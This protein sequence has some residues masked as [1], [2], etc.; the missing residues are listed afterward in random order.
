MQTID[1]EVL[2]EATAQGIV[3]AD[4][5]ERLWTFASSRGGPPSGNR[6]AAE[7]V[8]RFTFTNALYYLGGAL[9]VGAM[10]FFL[11]LGWQRFAGWGVIGISTAY[12]LVAVLLAARLEARGLELPMSL[13]AT[14]AVVLVPV[15]VWGFEKVLGIP[16]GERPIVLEVAA[17]L[18]AIAALAR[19]RSPI[20]VLPVAA[21]LWLASMDI[22]VELFRPDMDSASPA[23]QL[24]RQR[25][26]AVE[27]LLLLAAAFGVDL[28]LRPRRDFAFWIYLAGLAAAWGGITL[29]DAKSLPGT[30]VYLT[31]N[32]LL[33]VLGAVLVRRAFTVFGAVGVAIGLAS[34]GDRY[35]RNSWLFPLA[36]TLI[37]LGVVGFGL[38]WSRNEARLSARLQPLLP[39]SLREAIARR[40]TVR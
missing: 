8:A 30:L 19:F 16:V 1:R 10:G 13:L 5:A 2:A 38:W 11:E 29:M 31:G 28:R 26:S 33:V 22:T 9:A 32:A 36:L 21:A 40:R 25:C 37:G 14:L 34:L 20:L 18:A 24:F 6:S 27:G 3:T 7:L 35:L 4:Q 15:A 39:A 12:L 17:L 23:G